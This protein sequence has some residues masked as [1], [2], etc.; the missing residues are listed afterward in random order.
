MFIVSRCLLSTAVVLLRQPRLVVLNGDKSHSRAGATLPR[1]TAAY[2]L[3]T[4]QPR[5]RFRPRKPEPRT[6]AA[7]ST[8]TKT[9]RALVFTSG[10][11]GAVAELQPDRP[12]PVPGDDE[13]LVRVSR[14]A[15]CSTVSWQAC[16][17]APGAGIMH[18]PLDHRLPQP[19][20]IRHAIVT[21]CMNCDPILLL[22]QC[23]IWRSSR[24]MCLNLITY[25]GTSLWE[26]W[27]HVPPSQT[28]WASGWLEKSTA[29][30]ATSHV[31]M[32]CSHGTMPLEGVQH[33]QP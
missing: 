5:N 29:T 18:T 19:G 16:L 11:P 31:G 13:A 20:H 7:A 25:L 14:A 23:R 27:R 3:I 26:L 12:T 28:S 2:S 9:M 24:A 8:A 17:H 6:I 30:A 10:T 1:S 33:T 21:H 4:P 32:P 15:I 22:N